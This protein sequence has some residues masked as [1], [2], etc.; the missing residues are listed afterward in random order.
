MKSETYGMLEAAIEQAATEHAEQLAKW[1]N[2]L[3][4]AREEL[5]VLR[6]TVK[7]A[8]NIIEQNGA[9]DELC[10]SAMHKCPFKD[11]ENHDYSTEA[12]AKECIKCHIAELKKRAGRK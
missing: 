12:T 3:K 9:G 7:L 1:L 5:R 11:E 10:L 8:V 6:K 4:N 2:E